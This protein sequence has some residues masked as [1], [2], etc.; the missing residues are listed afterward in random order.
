MPRSLASRFRGEAKAL[1]G[2]R[3]HPRELAFGLLRT[4]PMDCP[5]PEPAQLPPPLPARLAMP[6]LTRPVATAHSNTTPW[7]T[8]CV[9]WI[10]LCYE[11]VITF[12]LSL[13]NRLV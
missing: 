4:L 9:T 11:C 2:L 5:T 6:A 1:C 7:V 8:Q 3:T 12:V 13:C 10:F